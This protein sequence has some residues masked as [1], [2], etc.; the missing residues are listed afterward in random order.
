MKKRFRRVAFSENMLLE[1]DIISMAHNIA[2]ELGIEESD[3]YKFKK[4]LEDF[5]SN[6]P[7]VDDCMV[8]FLVGDKQEQCIPILKELD[9][10]YIDFLASW[11]YSFYCKKS[12]VAN[13]LPKYNSM[14]ISNWPKS[15]ISRSLSLKNDRNILTFNEF[16]KRFTGNKSICFISKSLKEINIV[17]QH[18]INTIWYN[19]DGIENTTE[20]SPSTEIRTIETL[21]LVLGS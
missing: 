19:P 1:R 8:Y 12:F 15:D 10:P 5:N 9:I 20:I 21:D 2:D 11:L 4:Q 7:V 16:L 14:V 17:N 3:F 18:N 6:L 13:L